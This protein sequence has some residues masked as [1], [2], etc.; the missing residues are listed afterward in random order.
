MTGSGATGSARRRLLVLRLVGAGLVVLGLAAAVVLAVVLPRGPFTIVAPVGLVA[1]LVGAALL[2]VGASRAADV[3]AHRAST[4]AVAPGARARLALTGTAVAVGLATV[5]AA[6]VVVVPAI[7]PVSG[8]TLAVGLQLPGDSSDDAAPDGAGPDGS[9]PAPLPSASVPHTDATPAPDPSTIT[10]GVV[11]EAGV[12]FQDDCAIAQA[13]GGPAHCW[14]WTLTA[15]S[16]CEAHV[17]VHFGASA[18]ATKKRTESRFVALTPGVPLSLVLTGDEAVAGIDQPSCV[19]AG[20]A[21]YPIVTSDAAT[22]LADADFPAACDDTGCD[23]FRFDAEAACPAATVQM[24]VYDAAADQHSRDY[25]VVQAVVAST[26]TSSNEVFLP[27]VGGAQPADAAITSVT[28]E[29]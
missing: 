4:G 20:D 17:T 16:Q 2:V 24:A 23:G 3:A 14:A 18:D 9:A 28:C 1:V 10:V 25:V 27:Y 29:D 26:S 19:A 6:A 21:P 15:P 7:H 22:P 8:S 12:A 5:V 11:L 13:R